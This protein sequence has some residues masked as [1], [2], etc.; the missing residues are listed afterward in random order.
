MTVLRAVVLGLGSIATKIH[1]PILCGRA[2]ISIVGYI[3][4]DDNTASRVS[5]LFPLGKRLMKLEDTK[6]VMPEMVFV[7]SPKQTHFQIVRFFLEETDCSIFTEKPLAS[8]IEEALMIASLAEKKSRI[9]FVNLNRRYAPVYRMAKEA[10]DNRLP[11]VCIAQKNRPETEYR[12]TLENAIHM[13]DLLR[14]FCGEPEGVQALSKYEDPYFENS[15]VAS[16][17]F[18]NSLGILVA[19]RSSGEWVE[20]LELY[21]SNTTIAVD[22]PESIS[23]TREGV[24]S[25]SKLTPAHMGWADT[26]HRFGFADAI[27][28]FFECVQ[29]GSTPITSA[30]EAYRSQLLMDTILKSAGLPLDD[31]KE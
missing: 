6:S 8:T 5:G 1:L 26:S 17:Q 11:D 14:W 30:E 20:K 22:A 27:E 31:R 2:D 23:I 28:H 12:A 13:V 10:F 29:S 16:I 21:G 18:E 4:P 9:V 3:E 25:T 19:N 15:V 7:F 24:T